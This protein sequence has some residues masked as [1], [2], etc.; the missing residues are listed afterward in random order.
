[1]SHSP[2]KHVLFLVKSRSSTPPLLVESL[3]STA[4]TSAF[5][6]VDAADAH[7]LAPIS[8]HVHLQVLLNGKHLVVSFEAKDG[9]ALHFAVAIVGLDLLL[10][11]SLVGAELGV[12]VEV[13]CEVL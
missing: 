3:P 12:V 13:G 7:L 6:R 1:M 9:V 11:S 10:C 8:D 4:P 5:L 2:I